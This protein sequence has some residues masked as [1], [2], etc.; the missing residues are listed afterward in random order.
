MG[1]TSDSGRASRF[2]TLAVA[3]SRLLLLPH[4]QARNLA[5]MDRD[6]SIIGRHRDPCLVEV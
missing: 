4:S 2:C 6:P 3:P 1:D 5:R